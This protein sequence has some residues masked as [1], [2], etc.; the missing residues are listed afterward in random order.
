MAS[1]ESQIIVRIRA[2]LEGLPQ[3]KD[4]SNT[5]RQLLR[6][7]LSSGLNS[8]FE[9]T[10]RTV[11]KVR[12]EM[13]DLHAELSKLNQ[14]ASAGF[15]SAQE[16]SRLKE[17]PG[18]IAAAKREEAA[19]ER[20]NHLNAAANIRKR[21][22]A[23]LANKKAQADE[24]AKLEAKAA[25]DFDRRIAESAKRR[26]A[27]HRA[28]LAEQEQL[29]ARTAASLASMERVS[30]RIGGA[31]LAPLRSVGRFFTGIFTQ[32]VRSIQ[33][34]ISTLA[35]TLASLPAVGFGFLIKEGLEF[36][37]VM[38]QQ[39][40]GLAALI[41]STHELFS[42]DQPNKP[43][44][45][46]QAYEA[47]TKIAEAATQ[48][49]RIKIIPLAATSEDLLPIFNQIV[50]AGAQAGLTLEQMEDTFVSLAAAAQILQIPVA[51]LGTEIR[52]L[53][54][55]TVRATSRL[56]P[57]LFG[58]ALAAREF[59]KE[60]KAAGD[61]FQALQLKVVA[62]NAALDASEK[63][64]ATLKENTV[65][66]F[67]VLAGLATSGLFD[68][69]K[70]G[71][72]KI[73]K[74][75]LDLK[76]GGKIKPELEA[77]LNFINSG[78]T[79]FGTKL[80]ELVDKAIALILRIAKYVADNSEYVNLILSDLVK[81]GQELGLIVL[82]VGSV[83]TD[84]D[85]ARAKTASWHDVL[86]FIVTRLGKIRDGVNVVIGAFQF[87]GASIYAGIL[88]PLYVVLDVLGLISQSAA[89]AAAAIDRQRTSAKD[90]AESGGRRFLSGMNEDAFKAA[91]KS[92]NQPLNIA[93][94]IRSAVDDFERK[95]LLAK[96]KNG[97]AATG[98]GGRAGGGRGSRGD[99][100]L[101]DSLRELR[102][103]ILDNRLTQFEARVKRVLFVFATAKQTLDRQ[104]A[105]HL[106]SITEFYEKVLAI[107]QNS[108]DAQAAEEEA[109]RERDRQASN[110]KIESLQDKAQA[111]K[112]PKEREAF[113]N[114]AQAE[115]NTLAAK[116]VEYAQKLDEIAGRRKA[117]E[118]EI[119]NDRDRSLAALQTETRETQAALLENRGRTEDAARL[120]I[121]GQFKD[122]LQNFLTNFDGQSSD[123][124][125]LVQTIEQLGGVGT[126]QFRRLAAEGGISFESLSQ[127]TRDL[128]KL[129]ENLERASRLIAVQDR[130][131]RANRETD[132]DIAR[133]QDQL[134]QGKL[135]QLEYEREINR[136]NKDNFAIQEDL[137]AQAFLLAQ[138]EEDKLRIKEQLH[139][140]QQS[141][142][143]VNSFASDIN[144]T[145]R[146]AFSGFVGD[147]L[148]GN[149]DILAS[150]KHMISSM[151]IQMAQLLIQ[152]LVLNALFKALGIG[153]GS[154]GGIGGTLSGIFG[155]GKKLAKGTPFVTGPGTS[156]SDSVPAMLSV[157]EAVIPA[158]SVR[159]YGRNMIASIINGSF[160][161]TVKLASGAIVQPASAAQGAQASQ[162]QGGLSVKVV[163]AID[164]REIVNQLTGSDAKDAMLNLFSSNQSSFKSALGLA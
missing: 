123:V 5:L 81:I 67:Q 9:K 127:E 133:L 97:P 115:R 93:S 8:D 47:A 140:L 51:R 50:T 119:A 94:T 60:H 130:F 102:D 132:L 154:T 126:E 70:I 54:S 52:L 158:S 109:R 135:T 59:I 63:S 88:A 22:E 39:A 17:L 13:Q 116:E 34:A 131:D 64:Y 89:D 28:A 73:V 62:Y 129:M 122:Q 23:I 156:T 14:R 161:P 86:V 138:T 55:G 150:F 2:L 15:A 32:I 99:N 7:R 6:A 29:R 37:S 19:L 4:L 151:L 144:G 20:Q 120:R 105:N 139:Q 43:L 41:Q 91:Q 27:Q 143:A 95:E 68:K 159:R 155:G 26:Q 149:D 71:L 3:V 110:S 87:L 121:A 113:L 107:E 90:F 114:Q 148:Q 35:I 56:G 11:Q 152:T 124:K 104:L 65:E 100:R 36:N 45:G 162:G 82:A 24:D 72:D 75:F 108:L 142:Q 98:G 111:T 79:T 163:N 44:E 30:A 83:A 16:L 31:L 96:L 84:L 101:A 76:G 153:V 85:N 106:V 160:T 25:T 136:L 103:S 117:K 66:V 33:F 78:L 53:L 118:F 42:K 74:G 57:A 134:N 49:L 137:L 21:R 164:P 40:I 112:N 146:D 92:A 58:S 141:R 48:R 38:E 80:V 69:I 46:V 125:E 61:L 10:A 147:V 77:L 1:V 128:I 12:K 18:L 145:L 157:G